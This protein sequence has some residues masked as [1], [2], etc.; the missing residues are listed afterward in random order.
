MKLFF[1]H[2]LRHSAVVIANSEKEA[3][4]LATKAHA[5]AAIDEVLFGS[6][7]EW[8]D[9]TVHQLKLPNGIRLVEEHR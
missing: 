6:V 4:E 2:G 1:V 5:G 8:E 9:P 3:I 7:G